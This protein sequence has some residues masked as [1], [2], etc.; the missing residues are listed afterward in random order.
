MSK[1]SLSHKSGL[2]VQNIAILG[3]T[4]A[5]LEVSKKVLE[6]VPNVE[7]V[8]FLLIMFTLAF[9][10]KMIFSAT[11]FTILEIAWH[12]LHS[13]VIMY[14]YVWPLLIL[15]IWLFR[16]HAN[17]WFCSFVSAIYGLSFGALCSIVYIF[18]GGPYMAFTWWVAGIPWDIVHGV[19]NF[20]ICLFLY[21]PIDLA[22]KLILQ[23][24]ENNPGE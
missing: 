14:L 19:S 7:L 21:R 16:K 18:I 3:M 8:S 4:T 13:W 9:G 15:V 5:I 12:G 11:A 6:A 24:I 22:M 17:V 23:M 10:L 2:S 20:I 1:N